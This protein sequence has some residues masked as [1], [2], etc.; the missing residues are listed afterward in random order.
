MPD[1]NKSARVWKDNLFYII[2]PCY[3]QKAP[4]LDNG[5]ATGG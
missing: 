4:P 2:S 1:P 3:N 5:G